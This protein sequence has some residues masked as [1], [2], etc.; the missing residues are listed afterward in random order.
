MHA[1]RRCIKQAQEDRI[2]GV[3]DV[4]Q[5]ESALADP[6]RRIVA[7]VL[8][9]ERK[10]VAATDPDRLHI[11][12]GGVRVV[13]G[14]TELGRVAGPAD[15]DDVD[16]GP[17][18]GST[19]FAQEGELLVAGDIAE[20]APLGGRA[21]VGP[22]ERH[23]SALPCSRQR[24]LG[25][26]GILDARDAG[27]IESQRRILGGRWVVGDDAGAVDGEM[28]GIGGGGPG[29]QC[30]RQKRDHDRTKSHA[31]LQVAASRPLMPNEC[32]RYRRN[33]PCGTGASLC[34]ELDAGQPGCP[35]LRDGWSSFGTVT[36]QAIR[37]RAGGRTVIWAW[38]Q[39]R[40]SGVNLPRQGRCSSPN[41]AFARPCA[42][43]AGTTT[44]HP[45]RPA[46]MGA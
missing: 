35:G 25:A 19:P 13:Q 24:R 45:D 36:V 11:L 4:V 29:H 14:V 16:A 31:L 6:W 21:G 30:D 28:T 5:L 32:V 15:V 9:A 1:A 7:A 40:P 38:A 26:Q 44:V 17:G 37:S 39:A 23:V 41:M 10:D 27:A 3:R 33:R 43:P 20:E 12:H 42:V 8:Q 22:D 46:R 34:L 18:A 2:R